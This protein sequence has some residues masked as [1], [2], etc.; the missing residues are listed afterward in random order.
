M[1]NEKMTAIADAIRSKTGGTDKLGLDGMA[2]S[3]ED[4]Y[5]KGKQAEHDAFWDVYQVNGTRQGYT[6]AF[7]N[8]GWDNAIFK[9]K[10]DIKP[11]G[12]CACMF[13]NSSIR[14]FDECGVTID[15]SK[16]TNFNNLF[17]YCWDLREL[18]TIDCTNCTALIGVFG[19]CGS[20]KKIGCFKIRQDGS[21]TFTSPFLACKKLEDITIDGVIGSNIS[22]GDAPLLI[23]ASVQSIITSL[24]DLTGGTAQTL[25]LHADV[26][27]KL[28]DAQ[29]AQITAKNWTLA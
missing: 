16:G 4:V 29:R 1:V 13:Q 9:P 6:Y 3:V 11:T 28:T 8:S 20:L 7:S 25:T 21:N 5:D 10:Y 17:Y 14:N 22:F 2:S 27:A 18:P 26:K 23:T 24:K 12:S 19:Q 15:F